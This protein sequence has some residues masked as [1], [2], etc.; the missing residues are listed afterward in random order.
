MATAPPPPPPGGVLKQ[1]PALVQTFFVWDAGPWV[2]EGALAR[3]VRAG[4][5]QGNFLGYF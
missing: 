2:S 1:W 3:K 4:R 5:A